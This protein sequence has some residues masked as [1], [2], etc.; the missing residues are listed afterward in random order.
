MALKPEIQYIGQFYIHGSEAKAPEIKQEQEKLEYKLPLHRFE[1]VQKVHVDPLAICSIALAIVMLV[2][3]VS[4]TLQL[5]SAW[6]T[7]DTAN[8]YVYELEAVNRQRVQL[9]HSS[10]NLE[11]IRAAAA[12][13]GMIPVEEATVMAIAVMVPEPEQ[14]PTLWEDIVW[15]MEGL[16]A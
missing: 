7:L 14:K 12:T 10:Y 3:M 8:Q 15:F 5:Q 6:Q 9:Y 13:M 16:L 1:K 2:C 4:A 11:E